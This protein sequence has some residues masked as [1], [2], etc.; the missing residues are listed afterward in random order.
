MAR[1]FFNIHPRRK[2]HRAFFGVGIGQSLLGGNPNAVDAFRA[3][4][5]ADMVLR[6]ARHIKISVKTLGHH[7]RRNPMREKAQRIDRKL[8]TLGL[9]KLQHGSVA[10]IEAVAPAL[11][12]QQMFGADEIRAAFLARQQNAAFL[13]ALANRGDAQRQFLIGKRIS[14]AAMAAQAAIKIGFVGFAAGEYQRAGGKINLVMA[15][16][17]KDFRAGLGVA[18]HHDRGGRNQI[19]ITHFAL[20]LRARVYRLAL[21]RQA[22]LTQ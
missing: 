12:R 6:R 1:E 2:N 22:M 13:K 8:Q 14:A 4:M 16:H 9:G 17:H 3:V 7:L 5:S 15:H 21:K 10:I 20:P 19:F 11:E 18:Q